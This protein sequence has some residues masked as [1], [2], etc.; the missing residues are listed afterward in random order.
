M[1][2]FET[3]LK[4]KDIQGQIFAGFSGFSRHEPTIWIL[5][6]MIVF[7]LARSLIYFMG[8]PVNPAYPIFS[9]FKL[10]MSSSEDETSI[11]LKL[12]IIIRSQNSEY[13]FRSEKITV[14][15]FFYALPSQIRT[16]R[17][18]TYIEGADMWTSFRD[19]HSLPQLINL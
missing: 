15:H 1:L 5:M 11:K 8:H 19:K 3:W 18:I 9:L 10:P 4:F 6:I 12:I 2:N 13:A 16:V 7:K 14:K 17:N